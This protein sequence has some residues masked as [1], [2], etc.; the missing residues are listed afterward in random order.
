VAE[1]REHNKG[2]SGLSFCVLVVDDDVDLGET[3]VLLLRRFGY[4][5]LSAAS[6]DQ[7]IAIL[8]A[9]PLDLVV[10][11]LHMPGTDG[12][13][14]ARRAREKCPPIPVVL[15]TAYPMSDSERQIPTKVGTILIPKPFANTD[16]L[17][18]VRHALDPSSPLGP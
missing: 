1:R 3:L 9:E 6:G 13:A 2:D 11:D 10:T 8:D 4:T 5:C 17:D 18:A 14:V 15:M 7:A 12:L 16:M